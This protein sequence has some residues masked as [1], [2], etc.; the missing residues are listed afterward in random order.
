[1]NF[2]YFLSISLIFISS[3]RNEKGILLRDD[4]IRKVTYYSSEKYGYKVSVSDYSNKVDYII[5]ITSFGDLMAVYKYPIDLGVNYESSQFLSQAQFLVTEFSDSLS[6]AKL[7]DSPIL[8][9]YGS[10]Y[11]D[12]ISENKYKGKGFNV[13]QLEKDILFE[14]D[15]LMTANKLRYNPFDTQRRLFWFKYYLPL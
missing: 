4:E 2:F 1:M 8:G 11:M 9:Y 14:I 12:F 13:N 5:R 7:F 6:E 15:S 10:R 3:C